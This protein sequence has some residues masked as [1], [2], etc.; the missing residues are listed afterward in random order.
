MVQSLSRQSALNEAEK[1][2]RINA[3]EQGR[4]SIIGRGG[5]PSRKNFRGE[6]DSSKLA[7]PMHQKDSKGKGWGNRKIKKAENRRRD[8]GF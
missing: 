8:I 1:T 6:I 7:K 2:F 5:A 3:K 4:K